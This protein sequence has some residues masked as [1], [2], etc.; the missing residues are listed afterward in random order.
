MPASPGRSAPGDDPPVVLAGGG[1][2][3]TGGGNVMQDKASYT[4]RAEYRIGSAL[5]SVERIFTSGPTAVDRLYRLLED[6]LRSRYPDRGGA[7]G[8]AGEEAQAE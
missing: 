8:A 3:Y 4:Q 1:A 6:R 2:S 7:A 5:I